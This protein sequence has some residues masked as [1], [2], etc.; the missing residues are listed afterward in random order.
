MQE[1]NRD[2]LKASFQLEKAP[3]VT[4]KSD[5]FNDVDKLLMNR[6]IYEMKRRKSTY[7]EDYLLSRFI[8]EIN[9]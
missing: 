6:L 2:G 7:L 9:K 5:D 8:H 3:Q 1:A 4:R